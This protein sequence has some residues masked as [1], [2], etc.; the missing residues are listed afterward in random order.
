MLVLIVVIPQLFYTGCRTWGCFWRK[1]PR[2]VSVHQVNACLSLPRQV[3]RLTCLWKSKS[4]WVGDRPWLVFPVLE[5]SWFWDD[6]YKK[7]DAMIIYMGNQLARLITHR[8]LFTA[9][10]IFKQ[11]KNYRCFRF[12]GDAVGCVDP[13]EFTFHLSNQPTP[14]HHP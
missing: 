13:G 10:I 8:I 11:M 7:I 9:S 6:Q 3:P 4:K 14:F 1:V 12:E 5:W 2:E